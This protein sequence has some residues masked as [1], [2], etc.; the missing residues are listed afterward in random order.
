MP[1]ST[2]PTRPRL[3]RKSSGTL[4]V[5]AVDCAGAGEWE[6][7]RNQPSPLELSCWICMTLPPSSSFGRAERPRPW[8]P[9]RTSRRSRRTWTRP[10]R[11]CSRVIR[12]S[13]WKTRISGKST[14]KRGNSYEES[15]SAYPADHPANFVRDSR[16]DRISARRQRTESGTSRAGRRNEASRCE[17]QAE[18][19]PVHLRGTGDDQPERR[20]KE[21]RAF[22]GQDRARWQTPEDLARSAHRS[23]THGWPHEAA[24][25]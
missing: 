8:I 19:G 22:P 16:S 15:C 13:S 6:P 11:S 23:R 4:T 17:E 1:I 5:R 3:T 12:P 2:W 20:A 21:G 7:Q 18:F 24:C 25:G 10:C 14:D 9:A